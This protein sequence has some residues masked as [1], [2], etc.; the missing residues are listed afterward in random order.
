MNGSIS[1]GESRARAS[2]G[3]GTVARAPSLPRLCSTRLQCWCHLD[4]EA[5]RVFEEPLVRARHLVLAIVFATFLGMTVSVYGSPLQTGGIGAATSEAAV[6]LGILEPPSLVTREGHGAPSSCAASRVE[7]LGR[8][9]KVQFSVQT[10]ESLTGLSVALAER[11]IAAALVFL[12]TTNP[13][14]QAG[15]AR[16]DA[17][18]V[19]DMQRVF[20]SA[21]PAVQR[22]ARPEG[23]RLADSGKDV[24]TGVTREDAGS[25]YIV[26]LAASQAC[27][28]E[29]G[30]VSYQPYLVVRA[31][32][33]ALY[34]TLVKAVERMS[35]A[36]QIANGSD[37][38]A[39]GSRP[40]P[41][42]GHALAVLVV[43][44]LVG[45]AIGFLLAERRV[46]AAEGGESTRTL[47]RARRVH[48]ERMYRALASSIS[49]MVTVHRADGSIIYASR[50]TRKSSGYRRSALLGRNFME[51][52]HPE[53]RSGA[54]D[55]LK[56]LGA[57]QEPRTTVRLRCADGQYRFFEC[58][59][60]RFDG[61]RHGE[62]VVASRDVTDRVR[63]EA[64]LRAAQDRYRRLAVRDLRTG[65]PNRVG[66]IM[67]MRE[68][69][70]AARKGERALSVLFLDIDNLKT[71]NDAHGYTT[72]DKVVEVMSAR[73][74]AVTRGRCELT[75]AGGDEFIALTALEEPGE[76]QEL[77]SLMIAA[78]AQPVLLGDGMAY[79]TASVGIARY[80]HDGRDGDSLI[81][82]AGIALHAA[83]S[84]GKNAWRHFN[85]QLGKR[86]AERANSLRN[87][88]NAFERGEFALHYQPKVDL[89]TKQVNGYEALLRW[90]TADG[91]QET[92][93][94]IA[95][96]EESGFIA[97]LG[98][99]VLREAA[100]QSLAWRAM[101]AA[102]PIA[103]NVSV[104]QLNAPRFL[105]ALRELIA[106]DPALPQYLV[107]ELTETTLAVDVERTLQTLDDLSAMGFALHIDDF[108]VGYS[109][110]ARLSRMPV[111][112]LKIDRSFVSMTP[113]DADAREIVRAVVALAGTL[114]LQVVAEGVENQAQLDFLLSCGCELGQGYLF[115]RAI[116]AEEAL[117]LWRSD[118][119]VDMEDVVLGVVAA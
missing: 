100:R 87:L 3:A 115:G 72:G 48:A 36:H 79:L 85:P 28:D 86:A 24:G 77:A 51:F 9:A 39:P 19:A 107:L 22:G 18:A 65:L 50:S 42:S 114:R 73:L 7:P 34:E 76:L 103:V 69:V 32:L 30:L 5:L 93:A 99:W 106:K 88:R 12:P 58:V 61:G 41:Q 96:A 94:L 113:H 82:A 62:F 33:P 13:Q 53:D 47:R 21:P 40:W 57:E 15:H 67:R 27:K 23:R 108:G 26:A 44:A 31:D 71:I 38:I 95:A 43:I 70:R 63:A 116:R 11:N 97:T 66:L 91:P 1:L 75:R 46:S 20:A 98:D 90:E 8:R 119:S 110:L 25:H 84:D 68:A 56:A 60:R 45:V 2:L 112:A 17:A 52:V 54:R 118:A 81:A 29:A 111:N 37:G 80:P 10:Y 117:A 55:A 105:G 74:V 59:A 109:S 64:A 102:F 49:D 92:A 16:F 4:G 78:C 35:R 83:K 101:G 89:R 6:T 104:M 14:L